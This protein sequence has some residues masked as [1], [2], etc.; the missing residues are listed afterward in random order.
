MYVLDDMKNVVTKSAFHGFLRRAALMRLHNLVL[1]PKEAHRGHNKRG[2][3]LPRH[4]QCGDKHHDGLEAEEL[5]RRQLMSR[6]NLAAKL[7]PRPL[8]PKEA[9]HRLIVQ[10]EM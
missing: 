10:L 9:H 8:V 2:H 1:V 3:I 4:R 5:L 6:R 7:L